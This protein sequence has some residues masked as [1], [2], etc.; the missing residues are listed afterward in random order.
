MHKYNPIFSGLFLILPLMLTGRALVGSG[1]RMREIVL[2]VFACMFAILLMV[3][4]RK[5]MDPINVKKDRIIFIVPTALQIYNIA[6]ML[7]RRIAL[8]Y[9]PVCVTTVIL[10][11]YL[12]FLYRKSR[13]A[14]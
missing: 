7:I 1:S 11:F 2:L 4:Y 14:S 10:C 9:I 3:I 8:A 12:G 5:K 6:V 13:A